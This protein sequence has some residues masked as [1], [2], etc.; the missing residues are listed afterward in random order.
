MFEMHFS[1]FQVNSGNIYYE[2]DI[3]IPVNFYPN[4]PFIFRALLFRET[5]NMNSFVLVVGNPR[6][7]KS[8]CAIKIAEELS[9]IKGVEFDIEKQLTFDD[10]KKFL[11]WSRTATDSIFILDETGTALS[12]DQ[13]WSLQQRVM[14]RFIQTQGFRKNVLMWVLPSIVFIQK[15]FRFMSNYAIKTRRQGVVDVYKIVVD[16][17]LGKGYPDRIENMK[18]TM[19]SENIILKYEELK[20][21]WNDIALQGDIEFLNNIEKPYQ[22]AIP[23]NIVMNLFKKGKVSKEDGVL[24]LEQNGFSY[25]NA[26]LM[27]S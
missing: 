17:L 1:K 22:K 27:L 11:D 25:N 3:S 18:F 23:T 12:P 9:K 6:T 7:S 13:F 19:P 10:V 24:L 2:K 8:Y 20:K 21:A 4:L 5:I 16:Q 15:G 26:E 14:R